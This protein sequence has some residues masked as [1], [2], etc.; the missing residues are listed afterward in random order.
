MSIARREI[1]LYLFPSTIFGR[2][3]RT[4]ALYWRHLIEG[5]KNHAKESSKALLRHSAH[6][7]R[8][9]RL[10]GH[11]RLPAAGSVMLYAVLTG[12]GFN[13]ELCTLIYSLVLAMNKPC[14]MVLT[15]LNVVGDAA[16]TVIVSTSEKEFDKEIYN[17]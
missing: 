13:T 14:E 5:G 10:H 9:R 11:P 1:F 12:A 2:S 16:T 3:L 4:D 8:H 15:T 17:S 6:G 7:G